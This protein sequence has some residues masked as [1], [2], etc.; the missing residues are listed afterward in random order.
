MNKDV[1][2]PDEKNP[3]IWIN[4]GRMS[5]A[6]C[7]YKTRLPVESLFENLEGGVSLDEYIDAFEI[8]REQATACH[9]ICQ[10]KNAG[11]SQNSGRGMKIVFDKCVPRPLPTFARPRN[12]HGGGNGLGHFGERRFDPCRRTGVRGHHYFRPAVLLPTSSE[13]T[14]RI[15]PVENRRS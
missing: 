6:A 8:S 11:D 1:L 9:G 14:S 3:L 7:F 12:P 2:L 5:G 13:N 15:C 4:P 10:R